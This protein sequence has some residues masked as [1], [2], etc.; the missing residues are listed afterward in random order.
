MQCSNQTHPVNGRLFLPA[1]IFPPPKDVTKR[2]V[3]VQVAFKLGQGYLNF[4]PKGGG[5]PNGR[6]LSNSNVTRFVAGGFNTWSNAKEGHEAP[7]PGWPGAGKGAAASV[8]A[9]PQ[10]DAIKLCPDAIIRNDRVL[11][12]SLEELMPDIVWWL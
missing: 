5:P 4:P 1:F 8:V 10:P 11:V 3:E 2:W 9:K 6:M 7:P 12:H